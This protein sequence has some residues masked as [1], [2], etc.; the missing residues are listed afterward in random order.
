[1]YYESVM[2]ELEKDEPVIGKTKVGDFLICAWS[3][4]NYAAGPV[5]EAATRAEGFVTH[6]QKSY[7]LPRWLVEPRDYVIRI[8]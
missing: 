3:R 1:M 4:P 2:G 7:L 8:S 5:G 6:A